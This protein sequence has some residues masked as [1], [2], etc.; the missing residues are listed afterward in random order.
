[1]GCVSAQ[2]GF[3]AGI[4]R[5]QHQTTHGAT[6]VGAADGLISLLDPVVLDPGAEGGDRKQHDAPALARAAAN[7]GLVT[8]QLF[9]PC[10]AC[11][12]RKI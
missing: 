1:M 3:G 2:A 5:S 8:E 12:P 6:S 11:S 7:R 4:L 10:K 9:Q